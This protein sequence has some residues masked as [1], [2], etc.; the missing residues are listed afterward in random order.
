MSHYDQFATPDWVTEIIG[1]GKLGSDPHH[2]MSAAV[3]LAVANVENG[4]GP[5]SAIIADR[6]G[7]IIECGWNNVVKSC[8]S[9]AHAEIHCIR[10]A[11]RK[12]RSHDL[13]AVEGAPFDFYVSCA[14]C[15]QCFGA[16]YW[17]GLKRIFAGARK[18]HAEKLGFMEG[19]VTP[20]M[21]KEA[22]AEKGIS[23]IADLLPDEIV[24]RPFAAYAKAGGVIY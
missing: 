16:I 13:S 21:W 12:L 18:E 1:D 11:Q 10:R 9:T 5:F 6:N 4:G 3:A 22:A 19:P 24:V 15:I 7:K 2:I 20:A 17:S 8:D 23:Y 14:P